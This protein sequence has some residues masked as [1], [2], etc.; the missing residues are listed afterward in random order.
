MAGNSSSNA[1]AANNEGGDNANAQNFNEENA[2][3][4]ETQAAQINQFPALV[5]PHTMDLKGA[6]SELVPITTPNSNSADATATGQN[7]ENERCSFR[8]HM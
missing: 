4:Q 3:G 1:G 7:R 8:S 5:K 2:T 6:I